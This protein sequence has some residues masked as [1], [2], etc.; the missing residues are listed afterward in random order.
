MQTSTTLRATATTPTNAPRAPST[1]EIASITAQ[2]SQST[3]PQGAASHRPTAA[4]RSTAA[5]KTIVACSGCGSIEKLGKFGLTPSTI[6]QLNSP[7]ATQT[8]AS[9]RIHQTRRRAHPGGTPPAQ[10]A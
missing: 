10:A 7:L 6:D 8:Q 9:V 5:K 3:P 2:S 4:R 1:G